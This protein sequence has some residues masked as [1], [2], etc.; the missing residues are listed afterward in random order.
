MQREPR[1]WAQSKLGV[2][3]A[4]QA[5]GADPEAMLARVGLTVA[6]LQNPDT[7]LSMPQSVA[8]AAAA[9]EA[10]GDPL[11]GLH[12][13][14][15]EKPERLGVLAYVITNSPN[16]R[17]ALESLVRYFSIVSE[18]SSLTLTVDPP[19]AS[20][21][22]Q[23]RN[24]SLPDV[25][26]NDEFVAAFGANVLRAVAGPDWVPSEVH[27]RHGLLE[28]QI[29]NRRE[30]ERIFRAPI[31][32]GAAQNALLFESSVLEQLNPHA[33][34][35]LLPILESHATR[36][37]QRRP[38]L[39]DFVGDVRV[40]IEKLLHEGEPSLERTS[41]HLSMS[42]R[43]LQRRLSDVGW[44]YRHLVDETRRQLS[45]DYLCT[46]QRPVTEI[47]F[48]TGYSELSAFARAF[49]RWTGMTPI[50]YRRQQLG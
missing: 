9:A 33:D 4:L 2:V 26:Y 39:E 31:R 13:G 41:Q 40:E 12:W 23:A 6:D 44:S 1:V 27:F 49:R 20:L 7:Y 46:A 29:E 16:V 28:P 5:R 42:P 11:F 15:G 34:R 47:A 45:V 17:A 18:G 25:R 10:A 48:L 22:Y 8:L 30:Y 14:A 50:Q 43:T 36:L 21:R 3:G 19:N 38:P 35:E 32:F 24:P 37:Q